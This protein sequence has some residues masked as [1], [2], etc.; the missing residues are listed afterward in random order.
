MLRTSKLFNGKDSLAPF[1]DG[2]QFVV[3]K[4]VRMT[5]L[6]ELLPK[7]DYWERIR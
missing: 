6:M 1:V 5:Y 2:D 7:K 3:G 4:S